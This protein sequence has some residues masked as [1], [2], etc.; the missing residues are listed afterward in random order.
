MAVFAGAAFVR[1]SGSASSR[2]RFAAA[3]ESDGGGGR[4]VTKASQNR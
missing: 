4:H 3:A 2:E 1:L